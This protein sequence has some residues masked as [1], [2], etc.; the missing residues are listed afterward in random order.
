MTTAEL[1]TPAADLN[2][3]W[4]AVLA[5]LAALKGATR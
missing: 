3:A 4:T 2:Q 1:H 5:L